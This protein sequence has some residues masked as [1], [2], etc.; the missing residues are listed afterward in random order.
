MAITETRT[1]PPKFI[2]DIGENLAANLVASTAVPTVSV[3]L[4]QI[5]QRPGESADDFAARQ[6]AARAFETRQQSLAGLAPSVAAQ[7]ALQTRA[8]QLAGSGVGSYQQFIDTAKTLT[9]AGTGQ[10]ATG[11]IQDYM[12]PYQTQVIE[13]SLAE[14]DRNAAANRQRIRDQAVASGAFGGGRE[15]VELAEYQTGS[16]QDRL[17]L[18]ANLL[19]QGFDRAQAARQQDLAN[20]QGLAQLL[21]QLQRADISTLGSV[22]AVQQAQQQAEEDATREAARQATFLPQ[23]NL[24]RYAGQVAGLMGGYPGQTTQSFVPNPSPLQTAIGAGSALAGIFG[25]LK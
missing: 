23:E 21:P 13:T 3:G 17:M 11:L 20:Q 6:Q 22:G 5:S 1:R 16:D 9:G 8:A 25:A 18:Q 10:T 2:E 24:S 4:G 19:Q 14:F 12:S 7:D 15:G